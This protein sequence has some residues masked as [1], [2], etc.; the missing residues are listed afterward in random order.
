[1]SNTVIVNSNTACGLACMVLMIS[2]VRKSWQGYEQTFI[3]FIDFAEIN[4]KMANILP[5]GQLQKL[6]TKSYC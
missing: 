5:N 1:M 3:N 6:L 4:L 2:E